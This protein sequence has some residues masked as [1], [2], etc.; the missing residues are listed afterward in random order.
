[1]CILTG[2]AL[3]TRI[4]GIWE[5]PITGDEYFTIAAAE[6][7]ASGIIGSAY[8][9]LVLFSQFLFGKAEW[10]ARLPSVILGTLGIPAFYVL[11]RRLFN[12]QVAVVGG[13]FIILSEWHLY[14]S[15]VARFYSGVF[16]FGALAYYFYYRSVQEGQYVHLGL[17]YI[18]SLVA[19]AF[20]A[21][22]IFLV[23][24][25]GILSVL[26]WWKGSENPGRQRMYRVHSIV[27]GV[28]LL[29]AAPNFF[30]IAISWG[31]QFQGLSAESIRPLFA[32][33]EN[34]GVPIVVASICGLYLVLKSKGEESFY[35]LAV[36]TSIPL[37]SIV[38]FSVFL[39]PSRPRYMFY[40]LPLLFTLAAYFSVDVVSNVNTYNV[41][42]WGVSV[43]VCLIMS[44]SF[45]SYYT[46]RKSLDIKEPI[47]YVESRYRESDEVIVF[48]PSVKYNFKDEMKIKSVPSKSVWRGGI[49]TVDVTQGRMWII[50][51]TY[52]SSSLRGG[53]HGWLMKHASLKWR[54]EETRFDY[55]QRGYEVWLVGRQ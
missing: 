16:L 19:V 43:L 44:V 7:R 22:A 54:K 35:T 55:T 11:C 33:V 49:T 25:C 23:V 37:V 24:S 5:W 17:F 32:V 6:E 29:A 34:V 3:L 9:G 42:R 14:H 15:Q 41:K 53:M 52:R 31:G 4:Y 1:M 46:G 27:G 26:M 28:L 10:A 47:D 20:H 30:E 8:Y 45:L 21:T 39:P 12:R 13:V 18:F 38:L 36:L 51:D 40:S 50:V 2:L 48:G